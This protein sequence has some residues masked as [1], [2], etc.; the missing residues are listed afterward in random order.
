[1]KH[2]SKFTFSIALVLL[3]FLGN[4]QD[5]SV[6]EK[7]K[8]KATIKKD[9]TPVKKERY[10]LRL[11]V[12]LFKL[13]RSFYETDYRGLELVADYRLTRRHYLAAEIGNENK[14]IDDDQVNFTTKGTYIKVGFDFNSFQ[15]WGNME[16]IVSVGLRYGVSSF[17]QTLNSYQIYNPNPYFGESPVIISGENFD[18]LSA[19]WIE[20]VAGM[21]A[22][23]FNNV[24]VGFSFRL[25]RL[26]SQKIPNNFDNL[27]IPGFNRTYDGAFGV[28]FNYTVSYFIPLYKATVKPKKT[29]G[30]LAK[31]EKS[32]AKEEAKKK[33][34]ILE[35][36]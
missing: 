4:A 16:N 7:T 18:G 2:I 6:S 15:N 9:S 22:E 14:T 29:R 20:V 34:K 24:F 30:T 21:K 23:V 33:E 19:Q 31:D 3:S 35:R 32:E 36:K 27:Y 12:D 1:M 10:G 8:E 28:G 26:I 13:T 25:N 11:G 17:S 5:T